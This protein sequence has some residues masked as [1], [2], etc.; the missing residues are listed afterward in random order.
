[1]RLFFDLAST[2]W[3]KD[4]Q[5]EGEGRAMPFDPRSLKARLA[6]GAMLLGLVAALS[7][8]LVIVGMRQV[9]TRIDAA[10]AA[11]TRI[12]AYS[13]LSTQV[14][15]FLVVAT[16]AVQSGLTASTRADRLD[17]L[18][19]DIQQSFLRI[20]ADLDLS[21]SEVADFGI[22]AQSRR[23]TTSLAIARME[24]I[25]YS[26]QRALVEP[27]RNR[28]TLQGFVDTFA[29][30]F[31][32][33][34]HQAISDELRVRDEIIGG[35]GALK[36]R[37]TIYALFLSGL[38]ACLVLAAYFALI[39]PQFRRLDLLRSAA[40]R[41]AQEDFSVHLPEAKRDEIGQLFAQTNQMAAVLSRRQA[42]VAAEWA[43]L[44]DTIAEQ[45]EDLRAAN[46]ELSRKDRD[47]RRFFADISHELR[48]P[49][50]VIQL[51]A[52]LGR[53]GTDPESV[54]AFE[55]IHGRAERLA[56][57]I[58]DLLR[59]ARSDTG[60]LELET[61]PFGLQGMIAD[62]VAETNAEVRSAGM[63]LECQPVSDA[64]CLGDV[65]WQRQVLTSLIRNAVRHARD[66]ERIEIGTH[67]SGDLVHVTVT[68]YGPG[69][70]SE[71]QSV[72]FERFRQGDADNQ[73]DGFGIGLALAQWVIEKQG[74]GISIT[75]PLPN[76]APQGT[77]IT[78]GIP[79]APE[80]G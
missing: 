56:R 34:L 68:D 9:S 74:G 55:T 50:T 40:R 38:A 32:P 75:S 17:G 18:A 46:T 43:R 57:R 6:M 47:R 15:Q 4:V 27:G 37:L 62:A 79:L 13:V 28:E 69:I 16:E 60:Q 59:I 64:T 77:Q 42:Q 35:I 5:T 31:D 21:V 7:A 49:L 52:Q 3:V 1:M 10:L 30:G 54:A 20:R 72:L 66:G 19:L 44:T 14:S 61:A 70:P 2:D 12:D 41:I 73:G 67:V 8:A 53:E 71:L 51:E 58:D 48:T 80:P 78:L 36:Q 22:D 33:H 23:A 24:A 65:N 63:R 76:G 29:I 26:T 11:E 45:T 39:K 25:F